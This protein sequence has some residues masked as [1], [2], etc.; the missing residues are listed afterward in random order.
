VNQ[1]LHRHPLWLALTTGLVSAFF[2]ILYQAIEE[3]LTLAPHEQF[4]ELI[5]IAVTSIG[6][7]LAI[8]PILERIGPVRVH[9]SFRREDDILI[10]AGALLTIVATSLLHGLLHAHISQSLSVHGMLVLEQLLTA[11]VAPSLITLSWIYGVKR[12]RPQ[13][14]WY[15]LIVGVL[16]GLGL[17]LLAMVQLYF[18]RPSAGL[19]DSS[20]RNA[21]MALLVVATTFLWSVV[22]TCAVNGYLGGLATDRQWCG[23]AWSA[24]ALGLLIAAAVEAASFFLASS[25]E[26]HAIET[27]A[28][29]EPESLVS[30]FAEVVIANLGWAMGLWVRPDADAL[31]GGAHLPT[32]PRDV[33]TEV[34]A[35]V[36][37]AAS[38]LALGFLLSFGAI[39][40]GNHV[41]ELLLGQSR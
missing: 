40:L 24:V 22:P 8:E 34:S 6:M 1:S 15:G 3:F 37:S 12:E 16:T 21:A 33:K 36:V 25:L 38:M 39:A 29:I 17:V 27:A 4:K 31:L 23:K 35:G 9:D 13:A 18:F 28:L 5:V 32:T 2:S 30:L 10:R 26:S 19:R 14:R 41:T 20:P 11:L 7:L